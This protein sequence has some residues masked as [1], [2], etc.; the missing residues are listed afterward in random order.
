MI[1][2]NLK[3][4]SSL[5]TFALVGLASLASAAEGPVGQWDLQV[6]AQGQTMDATLDIK[7]ADGALTGTI[8]S[9]LGEYPV[10]EVSF[11]DGVLKF[12]LD[13]ADLGLAFSF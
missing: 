6:D 4:C 12:N 3:L 10:T 5:G 8:A 7:E 2:S 11:E 9:D 13:I 1:T